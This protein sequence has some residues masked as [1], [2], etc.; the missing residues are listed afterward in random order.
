MR[1]FSGESICIHKR[2]PRIEIESSPFWI[3]PSYAMFPRAFPTLAVR[4]VE[5]RSAVTVSSGAGAPV[6]VTRA[7]FGDLP[8][9]LPPLAF[10]AEITITVRIA[11]AASATSTTFVSMRRL[12]RCGRA[13]ERRARASVCSSPM[14]KRELYSSTYSW[15]S[16]P[17]YSAYVRRK[18]LTYVSAGSSS[19]CSSSSARRYLPRIFVASS[20]CANS[21]PR[22]TR[23]S[24]RLFPISNKARGRVALLLGRPQSAVDPERDSPRD[25]AVKAC[26]REARPPPAVACVDAARPGEARSA[27]CRER[28]Q[29]A[30]R[31]E[32]HRDIQRPEELDTVHVLRN[33]DVHGDREH[34]KTPEERG[35]TL[36]ARLS[37]A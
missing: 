10:Q 11:I 2:W 15:P 23:A 8:G 5:P 32:P 29:G 37:T 30:D 31:S 20:A 27:V 13:A 16:R 18:P 28:R 19:K 1:R 33:E 17:R 12:R 22:R 3:V 21:I 26:P 35:G 34:R 24:L 6:C 4:C 25:S 14:T 9:G 36:A 7:A